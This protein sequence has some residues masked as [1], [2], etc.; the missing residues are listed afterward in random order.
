MTAQILAS[1]LAN[2]IQDSKRKNTELRNVRMS[3]SAKM[4]QLHSD[5]LKLGG[6]EVSSGPEGFACHL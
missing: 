4:E 5:K 2:I 1:E 6:G 3:R